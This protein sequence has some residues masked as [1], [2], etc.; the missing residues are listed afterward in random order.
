MLNGKNVSTTQNQSK[1]KSLFG[2]S[3]LVFVFIAVT[4]VN[5]NKVNQIDEASTVSQERGLASISVSEDLSW[6][7]NLSSRLAEMAQVPAGKAARQASA[8]EN[9]AFGELKGSYLMGIQGEKVSEMLLKQ[10]EVK[11]APQFVGEEIAF[12]EKNK[13]L[14]WVGF[15]RLEVKERTQEKSVIEL[16]DA[17]KTVVG[18]ASFSWDTEGHLLSLKIN[19]F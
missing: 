15:E 9:F 11:D 19:K 2:I 10:K 7:K 13:S 4:F 8:I 12:L 5:Q 6:K 3:G 17:S 14:W 16:M 18:E 1:I